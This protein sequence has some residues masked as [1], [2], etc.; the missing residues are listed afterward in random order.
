MSCLAYT[1]YAE[2]QACTWSLNTSG[3][4][5]GTYD[6]MVAAVSG[7]PPVQVAAY[8]CSSIT[9]LFNP[10]GSG[11]W[12]RS[13]GCEDNNGQPT[14]DVG[15]G[16]FDCSNLSCVSGVEHSYSQQGGAPSC[17]SGCSV[18]PFGVNTCVTLSGTTYCQ[19][20]VREDGGLCP[21]PVEPVEGTPATPPPPGCSISDGTIVCDCTSN[22]GSSLCG[23]P[24]PG[25][26]F[27]DGQL[28]CSEDSGSGGGDSGGGAGSGDPNDNN[29]GGSGNG[30]DTDTGGNDGTGDG[31]P[32]TG[33]GTGGDTSS[34]T[35]NG[36]TSGAG[37]R[38]VDCN[39]LSNPDCPFS[40]NAIS[41]GGCEEPPACSG[42]SPVDC[43]ILK[44][45]WNS[46]CYPFKDDG[47]PIDPE[48]IEWMSEVE[49]GELLP[50]QTEVDLSNANLDSA[51]F[52]GGGS[53]PANQS[54]GLPAGLG[55]F[56]IDMSV[57]CVVA[58]WLSFFVMFMAY[59]AAFRIAFQGAFA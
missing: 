19:G 28:S 13:T 36:D 47:T 50:D 27:V 51:G 24:P 15:S 46:Q 54:V 33:G 22:P 43:A 10:Y 30:D 26:T 3:Q 20:Q 56:E 25:C 1:S 5:S 52:L 57:F 4:G 53:C 32:D 35:G 45:T 59:F 14:S 7:E 11:W 48:M 49:S 8:T 40:G 39:P 37:G 23:N 18:A 16:S 38:D 6:E 2:A 17:V 31:N 21:N 41:R 42:V 55:S 44:Q 34:G 12:V 29:D 9:T 58:E